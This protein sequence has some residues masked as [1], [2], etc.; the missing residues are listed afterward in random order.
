V[1]STKI[2]PEIAEYPDSN[3]FGVLAEYPADASG[4]PNRFM[5]VGREDLNVNYWDGE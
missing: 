1:V 5:F 3:K 4:M 2:S